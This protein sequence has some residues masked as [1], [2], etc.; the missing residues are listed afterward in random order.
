MGSAE[1][2]SGPAMI[3]AFGAKEADGDFKRRHRFFFF[4]NKTLF[5]TFG[6]SELRPDFGLYEKRHLS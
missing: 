1:G 6:Y 5:T 4:V 3:P 2:D